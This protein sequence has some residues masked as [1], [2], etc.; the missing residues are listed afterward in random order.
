MPTV[1]FKQLSL[2]TPIIVDADQLGILQHI[3]ADTVDAEH[4]P[5]PTGVTLAALTVAPTPVVTPQPTEQLLSNGPP[6][7]ICATMISGS[8]AHPLFRAAR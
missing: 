7:R 1:P 6:S 3:W 5:L 4:D 8:F 2:S